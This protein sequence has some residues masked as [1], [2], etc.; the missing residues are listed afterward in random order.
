MLYRRSSC[1]FSKIAVVRPSKKMAQTWHRNGPLFGHE[2]RAK[3][4]EKSIALWENQKCLFF[5]GFFCGFLKKNA[6]SILRTIFLGHFLTKITIIIRRK[7]CHF[8]RSRHSWRRLPSANFGFQIDVYFCATRS[9]KASFLAYHIYAIFGP[10]FE[11]IIMRKN[12]I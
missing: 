2:T 11:K 10:H 1:A 7:T 3:T 5:D 12:A 6:N 8:Y 4:A 9:T